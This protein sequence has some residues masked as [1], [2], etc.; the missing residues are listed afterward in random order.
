MVIGIQQIFTVNSLQVIS[1][2]DVHAQTLSC[3][4]LFE[5]PWTVAHQVPLSMRFFRQEY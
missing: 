5:M 1:V 4:L 2:I 3:V